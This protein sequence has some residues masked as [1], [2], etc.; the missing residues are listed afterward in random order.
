MGDKRG[1]AEGRGGD[2]GR[3]DRGRG[4]R[5][6]KQGQTRLL[7]VMANVVRV[8]AGASYLHGPTH[9]SHIAPHAAPHVA[10][11]FVHTRRQLWDEKGDWL[12]AE[13]ESAR[14]LHQ[15][16]RRPITQMWSE[17]PEARARHGQ[18]GGGRRE[19]AGF[20]VGG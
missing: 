7:L 19:G 6:P 18:V 16:L 1:R 17:T 9:C 15:I 20:E 13:P 11:H 14:A 10:Q 4:R 8:V 5:G 3:G 12:D 2:K